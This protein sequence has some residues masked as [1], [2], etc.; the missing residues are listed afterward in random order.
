MNTAHIKALTDALSLCREKLHTLEIADS[1]PGQYTLPDNW[2]SV[3]VA[4]EL[5]NA[6]EEIIRACPEG[7][8]LPSFL[9]SYWNVTT[10]LARNYSNYLTVNLD[11]FTE[12]VE[13]L[14]SEIESNS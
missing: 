13:L 4:E 2:D 10:M 14:Q 11:W 5:M 3:T 7:R 6:G 1:T 8:E 9:M 12:A